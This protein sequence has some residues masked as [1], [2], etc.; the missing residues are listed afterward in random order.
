MAGRG[1]SAEVLA[2]IGKDELYFFNLLEFAW[3]EG[4][5]YITDFPRDLEWDGNTYLS[6]GD[7][8]SVPVIS[9]TLGIRVNTVSFT[10]SGVNQSN[11]SK[12]LST[13]FIGLP[14]TIYRGFFSTEAPSVNDIIEDPIILFK[15]Y[16]SAFSL[17]E[18]PVTGTSKLS[19]SAASHWSDFER[20][21]GRQTN[22]RTHQELFPGDRFFEYAG[23][24]V[25]DFKWG[26]V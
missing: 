11:I 22:D 12:A 14:I 24:T 17:S 8:L 13:N 5:D 18:D 21:N 7:L 3:N 6:T 26:R 2:E 25:E 9:E 16:I 4:T 20:K 1:M 23:Q 15:G 19:W 10:L